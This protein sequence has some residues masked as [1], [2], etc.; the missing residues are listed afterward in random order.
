MDLQL[1]LISNLITKL[2]AYMKLIND[3]V[4]EINNVINENKVVGFKIRNSL[5]SLNENVKKKNI[6]DYNNFNFNISFDTS[7]KDDNCILNNSDNKKT[8]IFKKFGKEENY[9]YDSNTPLN[10]VIK[11]YLVDSGSLRMPK[12]PIFLYKGC[13]LNPND[14]RKIGDI[15]KDD[16]EITVDYF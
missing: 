11:N 5:H 2:N 9:V 13:S 3:I 1:K 6:T 7:E 15:T 12:K 14:I 10:K 8:V 16:L 4:S